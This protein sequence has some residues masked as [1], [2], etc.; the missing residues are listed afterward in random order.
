VEDRPNPKRKRVTTSD[1]I[2]ILVENEAEREKSNTA[3]L[4]IIA[5]LREQGQQKNNLLGRLVVLQE[6][7]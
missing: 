3:F 4:E 2:K 1:I 7:K 5:D 6:S